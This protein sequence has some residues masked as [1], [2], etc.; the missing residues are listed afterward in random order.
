LPRPHQP[1]E[2][3]SA[4]RQHNQRHGNHGELDR[5]H[6]LPGRRQIAPPAP[7]CVCAADPM[8]IMPIRTKV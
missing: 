2:L 6:A 4:E 7:H 1:A 8:V 5:N 3:G